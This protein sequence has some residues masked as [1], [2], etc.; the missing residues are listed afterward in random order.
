M[1]AQHVTF[2]RLTDGRTFEVTGQTARALIA[3]AMAGERGCTSL[4][5]SSWAYRLAHY[6]L[7][8]RR[9][10]LQIDMRREEH[11]GGW[12]G[13]YRLRTGVEILETDLVEA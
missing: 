8:L 7:C 9:L 5:V 1:S 12:H 3:L 10:G 13:R 4:E 6:V 11:H 2:R